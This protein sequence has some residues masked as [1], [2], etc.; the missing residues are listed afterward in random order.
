[1][2]MSRF[3][4]LLD[5]LEVNISRERQN[6]QHAGMHLLDCIDTFLL[7][8]KDEELKKRIEREKHVFKNSVIQIYYS[9]DHLKEII[10]PK[11]WIL[12]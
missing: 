7:E 1:M 9:L 2:E 6:V 11:E 3:E 12:K 4:C 8:C 5:N 10:H